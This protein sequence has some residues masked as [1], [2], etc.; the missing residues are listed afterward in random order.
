MEKKIILFGGSFDPIHR[1]HVIV[2]AA[3][4]EYIAADQVV[5]IPAG[6]SP[7]KN[8]PPLASPHDRLNMIRLAI[9]E[10]KKF[11]ATVRR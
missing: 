2:A 5:L 3:A 9:A 4:A 1:G 7:H 10:M 11:S 6:R 8:A